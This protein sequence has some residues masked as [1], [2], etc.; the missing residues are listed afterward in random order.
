MHVAEPEVGAS[1]ERLGEHAQRVRAVDDRG[2]PALGEVGEEPRGGDDA[3]G[4]RA[5]VVEDGHLG[6]RGEPGQY[7]FAH[8]VLVGQRRVDGDPDER[9]AAGG[10]LDDGAV[11]VVGDQDLLAVGEPQGAQGQVGALGGVG[12]EGHGLRVGAGG[13]VGGDPGTGLGHPVGGADEEGV[14]VGVRLLAQG[15]LGFLDGYRHGAEGPVVEVGDVR[16]QTEESGPAGED[17]RGGGLG[18]GCL[19]VCGA[20]DG[21]AGAAVL[22]FRIM[23]GDR[24][25]RKGQL[26]HGG[27]LRGCFADGVYGVR[28]LVAP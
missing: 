21:C 17:G 28:P 11:A 12:D 9:G 19:R 5:D 8:G 26:R 6:A 25:V 24:M 13:E 10:G 16:V 27:R 7:G 20:A 4:G 18:H 22:P 3:G 1:G 23:R 15:P 14:G 2:D